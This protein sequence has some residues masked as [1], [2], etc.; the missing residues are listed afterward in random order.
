MTDPI[1]NQ[2]NLSDVDKDPFYSWKCTCALDY[3]KVFVNIN[4]F[5]IS[6]FKATLNNYNDS[7]DNEDTIDK[8]NTIP[9][10]NNIYSN[11]RFKEVNNGA[12]IFNNYE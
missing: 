2:D 12:D 4:K 5:E 8:I 6:I 3:T 9:I 11:T 10:D 7:N 1:M